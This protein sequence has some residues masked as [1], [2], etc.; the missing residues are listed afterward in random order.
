MGWWDRHFGD[1]TRGRIVALLR[2]GAHSV[3]ELAR[4][5]GLTDNAV[6][7]QLASLQ[8]DGVV[9]ETGVR[10]DGAVGKPATI[11]GVARDADTLFSSAY[12]PVLAALLAEL[13]E[14]MTPARLTTL[15]RG[16]GRRLAAEAPP[17]AT[18][19][20]RVRAAAMLLADLGGDAD[21]LRT[22]DGWTIQGHGC[23]LA[24][25]VEV[26]P[27]ACRIV[28]QMLEDMTQGRVCERCDR[29][30]TPRCRF[31]ITAE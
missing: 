30:D 1:T 31:V 14:R 17:A 22:R 20:A 5:L 26:R 28:E 15:L 8:R 16:V 7:A 19:D 3:E 4:A 11:Y 21:L 9:S 18:F 13:A 2:R 6:R 29:G 27:E 25:A 23:P 10:R 24:R 12:A